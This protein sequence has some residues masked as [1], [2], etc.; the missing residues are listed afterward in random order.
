MVAG[1]HPIKVICSSKQTIPAIGRS[2]VKNASQGKIKAIIKRLT[3]VLS[4]RKLKI[5]VLKRIS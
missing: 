3:Q 2:M 5:K 1:S 4:K